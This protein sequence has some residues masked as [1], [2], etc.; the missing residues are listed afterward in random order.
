MSEH[1]KPYTGPERRAVLHISEED[2][3]LLVQEVCAGLKGNK[4]H[5]CMFD[6]ED[7]V[8]L[9]KL[10]KNADSIIASGQAWRTAKKIGALVGY[11]VLTGFVAGVLM[12]LGKVFLAAWNWFA[13]HP[14]PVN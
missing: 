1:G 13:A 5:T 10:A 7:I 4:A 6:E 12:V 8:G 11:T 3:Q 9:K 14:P 2:R